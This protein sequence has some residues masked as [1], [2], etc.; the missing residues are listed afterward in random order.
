MFGDQGRR[1]IAFAH[2]F[3][4]ASPKAR[5]SVNDESF[6]QHN[7]ILLGLAAIMDPPRYTV[8]SGIIL[9]TLNREET[10]A[11]IKLCKEAGV[12]VFMITGDHPTTAAAVARH[13]G[14]IGDTKDRVRI[15]IHR[16]RTHPF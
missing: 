12:K 9:T 11:A 1:V 15:L 7:M 2:K 4:F 5:F 10:A 8:V 14:L 3:F 6:S 16:P 13:I